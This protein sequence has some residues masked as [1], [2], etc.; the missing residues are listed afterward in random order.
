MKI[1]RGELWWAKFNPVIGSE[2][3]G[4]RPCVIIQNNISNEYSPTIIVSLIT[5]KTQTKKYVSNVPLPAN[6]SKLKKEST[7]LLNQIRTIDKKRLIKKISSLTP[8]K[9]KQVDKAIKISLDLDYN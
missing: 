7:M 2:Q 4:I 1:K 5:S 6:E 8:E 9:M 3:G